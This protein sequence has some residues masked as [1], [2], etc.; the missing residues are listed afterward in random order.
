MLQYKRIDVLDGID[1]YKRSSSRKCM[2]CHYW[3]FKD[4]GFKLEEDV[5]DGCHNLLAMAYGLEHIAILSA[6][7]PTFRGI[8]WDISR[9]EGLTI[10]KILC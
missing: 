5:C 6:K 2:L 10:L 9:N 8:L 7:G 1:V 3:F 4:L